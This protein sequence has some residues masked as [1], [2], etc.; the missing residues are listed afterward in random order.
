M[1]PLEGTTQFNQTTGSADYT[2]N[3]IFDFGGIAAKFVRINIYS[4]YGM[5]SQWGLSEVQFR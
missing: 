2:A 4:G 1:D 5:W 3:T